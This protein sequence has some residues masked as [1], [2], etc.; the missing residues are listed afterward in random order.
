MPEEDILPT[1]PT[2]LIV[3]D[4]PLLRML[5]ADQLDDAG[6]ETIEAAS[7]DEAVEILEMGTDVAVMLTDIAMPGSM[8]GLALANAV[9]DRWPPVGIIVISGQQAVP[10]ADLPERSEFLAKPANGSQLV[11]AVGRASG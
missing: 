5:A 4:E 10:P 9:R 8:D 7:A 2:V 1:K 11:S 6:F 3:E